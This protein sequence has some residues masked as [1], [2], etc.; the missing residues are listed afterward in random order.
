LQVYNYKGNKYCLFFSGCIEEQNLELV[1]KKKPKVLSLDASDLIEAEWKKRT[2][3]NPNDYNGTLLDII[4]VE[5]TKNAVKIFYD[6]TDYK[7]T[8]GTRSKNYLKF[9]DTGQYYTNHLSVAPLVRTKDNKII[10]GSDLSFKNGLQSWKFPGGYFDPSVDK[11][12][13]D[14]AKR[15]LKEEIGE[16][17]ILNGKIISITQ[18]LKHSFS[19]V[20][21]LMDCKESSDQVLDIHQKSEKTKNSDEMKVIKFIEFTNTGVSS[22]L[23]CE[24]ISLSPSTALSLKLIEFDKINN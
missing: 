22:V 13:S 23:D 20:T 3:E 24:F 9:K 12:L 4:S 18:N 8:V 11:L 6:Y 5:C 15:E 21:F 2:Q 10:I 16:L 14:C 7:M 17:S 1:Y 19:F